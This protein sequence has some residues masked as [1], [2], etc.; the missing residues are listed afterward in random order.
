LHSNGDCPHTF[1]HE[2]ETPCL[3]SC[4][5]AFG[6]SA[7]SQTVTN[8]FATTNGPAAV[9]N[10]Y[11]NAAGITLGFTSR[12]LSGT[13]RWTNHNVEVYDG[14]WT[15]LP[16][17]SGT[18]QGYLRVGSA[19][20]LGDYAPSVVASFLGANAIGDGNIVAGRYNDGYNPF[21][22]NANYGTLSLGWVNGTNVRRIANG[23]YGLIQIG[24][25]SGAASSMTATN[26]YGS[27]QMGD[28][29][30]QQ[31]IY[32]GDGVIQAQGYRVA[33]DTGCWQYA[34]GGI[35]W[36]QAGGN[37]FQYGQDMFT[38]LQLAN[39]PTTT[40]QAT[41]HVLTA[42]TFLQMGVLGNYAR[43][44]IN[45]ANGQIQNASVDDG[46]RQYAVTNDTGIQLLAKASE[47]L[48]EQ[49]QSYSSVQ[50]GHHGAN[51][52]LSLGSIG[53]STQLQH[54][55]AASVQMLSGAGLMASQSNCAAVLTIGAVKV[56]GATNEVIVGDGNTSHGLGAITASSF[57][58][59]SGRVATEA[60]VASGD[61]VV[62]NLLAIA[63]T[64][65]D[66]LRVAGDVNVTNLAGIAMSN[67]VALRVAGDVNVTNL[68]AIA[69]TNRAALQAAADAL[70]FLTNGS[71][72]ASYVDMVAGAAAPSGSPISGQIRMYA[73]EANG[74]TAF[75]IKQSDGSSYRV[76]RDS[77]FTAY[78]AESYTITNGQL[79]YFVRGYMSNTTAHLVKL[80]KA[81]DASTMPCA[82]VAM[83]QSGGIT[84]NAS[85]TFAFFGRTPTYID[86]TAF[87][88]SDPLYVSTTV[89]GAATN[90]RPTSPNIAQL[91]GYCNAAGVTNGAIDVRIA[92]PVY[93]EALSVFQT[94]QLWS[95]SNSTVVAN[96]RA[97]RLLDEGTTGEGTW[98]TNAYTNNHYFVYT[99]PTNTGLTQI[100][101][102][103][104]QVYVLVYR[105]AGGGDLVSLSA[106]IY[107]RHAD[108][109]ET[110]L[111]AIAGTAAQ[112]IG[113]TALGYTFD[114]NVTNTTTLVGTDAVMLKFKT[115][116][117]GGA[118]VTLYFSTG[119]LK[120]PVPTSQFTLTSELVSHNA[121]AFG[122]A[123]A[124]AATIVPNGTNDVPVNAADMPGIAAGA[125][126]AWI[127]ITANGTNW[128]VRGYEKK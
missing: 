90:A 101:P 73:Q 2:E 126:Q 3:L 39:G 65:S 118:P 84:P 72:A 29:H 12:A 46:A 92:D 91:V 45:A 18:T 37:V 104:Y 53:N 94:W 61:V 87:G 38:G 33:M 86:T 77:V 74:Q 11:V 32:P 10:Q 17:I 110:E 24:E 13:L 4:F 78:N 95:A 49:S 43:Q 97:M 102:S 1:G 120:V 40:G 79:V 41:Q 19:L 89:A 125:V 6:L 56:D 64:N 62:T 81:N 80:A 83:D 119:Y 124:H 70:A 88:A 60:D 114:L 113:P 106:E 71:R 7:F 122:S 67:E 28:V 100:S 36:Q 103:L 31:T 115:S 34:A 66:A 127:Q 59:G 82:G 76:L 54:K 63:I 112:A 51:V 8:I 21:Y 14:G 93:P 52:D 117:I 58:E 25:Q 22:T 27:I 85:G 99:T 15:P 44:Y 107:I 75:Y 108:G 69:D 48:Q 26:A 68:A 23:S 55:T 16:Q 109:S 116:A 128:L 42:A 98:T 105:S 111:T 20:G 9:S 50:L 35:G 5:L 123:S 96:A 121:V 30:G 57:W 47:G